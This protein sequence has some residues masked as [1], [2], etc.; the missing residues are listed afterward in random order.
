GLVRRQRRRSAHGP[1][2]RRIR[3]RGCG[4]GVTYLQGEWDNARS[5]NPPGNCCPSA[6]GQS[7]GKRPPGGGLAEILRENAKGAGSEITIAPTG[8][9]T[10][11]PERK[12]IT[13]WRELR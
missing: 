2:V 10:G 9:K 13:D 11:G 7:F 8:L 12:A 6:G 3:I 5:G 4:C 1:G